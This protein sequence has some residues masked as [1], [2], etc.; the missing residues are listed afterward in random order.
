MFQNN[1][2]MIDIILIW[3]R[4]STQGELHA[5]QIVVMEQEINDY[6]INL[7]FILAVVQGQSL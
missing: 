5:H 1:N 4:L 2:N 6:F 3:K 7:E